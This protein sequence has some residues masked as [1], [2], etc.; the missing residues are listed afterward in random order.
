[1]RVGMPDYLL[2]FRV[3]GENTEP[4]GHDEKN[5]PVE[6]WQKWASPVWMH[7]RQTNTLNVA[8]ACDD[9]DER[10]LCPLQLDLIERA[11]VMWSNP[12]DLVLSPFMGVGSEGYVALKHRRRFLGV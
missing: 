2:V 1:S 4:V 8:I 3:P 12:G 9:A 7:I 5:F 11:V 10:H 6:Q